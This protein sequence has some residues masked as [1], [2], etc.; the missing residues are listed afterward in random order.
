MHWTD[1]YYGD[2]YLD[3]VQDLL[4][5]ELSALE[6]EVIARLL[7]LRPGERVLDLA[8]GHGRHARV[9]AGRVGTLVGLDRSGAYLRR[10][11]GAAAG[12]ARLVQGDLRALPLAGG[13]F[14]AVY[15]WYASLFMYDEPGNAAALAELARVLRP[16][17]RA[18]VHHGNPL[19]L[20]AEPVA[21]ARRELPG[22]AVVEEVASFDARTGVEWARRRLARADGTVLEGAA[23]LRYYRADEWEPLARG[24]GLALVGVTSTTG[25]AGPE[26]PDLVALLRRP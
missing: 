22:G 25:A 5:P 20:A 4:T 24:A 2:L 12:G 3:T 14:D 17:G 16:G 1:T 19:G 18:L 6:G 11:Q 7:A 9:L 15:S 23:S 13:A 8:C 10:A 21:T 26:A